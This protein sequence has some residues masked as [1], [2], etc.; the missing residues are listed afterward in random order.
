MADG[1]KSLQWFKDIGPVTLTRY[2]RLY[3]WKQDAR[4][5]RH[6]VIDDSLSADVT[7]AAYETKAEALATLPE[8]AAAWDCR[9]AS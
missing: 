7:G 1:G 8:T 3:V 4:I 6:V 5:W 9:L 2:E